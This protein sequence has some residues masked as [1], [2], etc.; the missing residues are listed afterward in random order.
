M[1]DW[2]GL[3]GPQYDE[4]VN[5]KILKFL[6]ANEKEENKEDKGSEQ[7]SNETNEAIAKAMLRTKKAVNNLITVSKK[8]SKVQELKL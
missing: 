6:Q 4:P 2:W 7:N 1:E 8:V 3:M 5:P